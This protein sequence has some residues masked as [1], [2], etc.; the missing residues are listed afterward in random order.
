MLTYLLQVGLLLKPEKY[1]FYKKSVDFLEF[2]VTTSSVKISPKK[3][4][5]IKE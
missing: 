5:A 4:K 3:V 1:E 2:I